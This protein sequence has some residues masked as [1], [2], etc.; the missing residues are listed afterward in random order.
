MDAMRLVWA[1]QTLK[2]WMARSERMLSRMRRWDIGEELGS[3]FVNMPTHLITVIQ[4]HRR[5]KIILRRVSIIIPQ[6]LGHWY[7]CWGWFRQDPDRVQTKSCCYHNQ[8]SNDKVDGKGLRK[9]RSVCWRKTS[10]IPVL[11]VPTSNDGSK[12]VGRTWWSRRLNSWI[13]SNSE[14]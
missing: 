1:M 4:H 9:R 10:D 7:C 8:G 14:L 13:E 5:P 12:V 3:P 11:P 6:R 2:T